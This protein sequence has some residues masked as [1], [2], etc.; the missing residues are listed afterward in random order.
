MLIGNDESGYSVST[1]L[2]YLVDGYVAEMH[3]QP[4][5]GVLRRGDQHVLALFVHESRMRE[6]EGVGIREWS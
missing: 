1:Y 5:D 2:V 6:V 3:E 4:S